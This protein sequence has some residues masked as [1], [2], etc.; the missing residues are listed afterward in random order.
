MATHIFLI[1]TTEIGEGD[2]AILTSIVF[3][4]GWFNHQPEKDFHSIWTKKNGFE[5]YMPHAQRDKSFVTRRNRIVHY[6]PNCF[7]LDQFLG[8]SAKI[9]PKDVLFSHHPLHLQ[10]VFQQTHQEFCEQ[11]QP[12]RSPL[13]ST[14][15][16]EDESR[17]SRQGR[18]IRHGWKSCFKKKWQQK[19]RVEGRIL[20]D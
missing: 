17:E 18:M 13:D 6:Y 20:L 2:E 16:R 4:R 15:S 3:K 8:I 12:S 14:T 11:Q 1:F 7:N 9:F 19:E 10:V 5:R